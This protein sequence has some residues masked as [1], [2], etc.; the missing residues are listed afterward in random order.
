MFTKAANSIAFFDYY[1]TADKIAARVES[2]ADKY[3][4][5]SSLTIS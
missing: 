5:F 4:N 1:L 2:W 3:A